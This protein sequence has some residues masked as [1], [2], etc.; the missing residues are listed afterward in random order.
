MMRKWVLVPVVAWI[1]CCALSISWAGEP[2]SDESYQDYLKMLRQADMRDALQTPSQVTQAAPKPE[3]KTVASMPEAKAVASK[4]EVK[5]A[6]KIAEVKSAPAPAKAAKSAPVVSEA[7]TAP[8]AAEVKATPVA[9][10]AKAAPAI[11]EAKTTPA[12]IEVKSLPAPAET[13]PALLVAQAKMEPA[14]ARDEE[15][16]KPKSGAWVP[17]AGTGGARVPISES[18]NARA[19]REKMDKLKAQRVTMN[20]KETDLQNVI[21]ALARYGELNVVIPPEIVKG[22]VTVYL[23]D[24]PLLTAFES[25]L[26]SH[27]LTYIVEENSTIIRIAPIPA[28]EEEKPKLDT[29]TIPLNWIKA[30]N[31]EMVLK[32]IVTEGTV[33]ADE[34]TNSIIITGKPET[35]TQVRRDIID[36][37]D[38]PDKQVDIE[39]RFVELTKN[40]QRDLGIQTDISRVDKDRA[41]VFD[42]RPF[43]IFTV[44]P[45]TGLPVPGSEKTTNAPV[46]SF[47]VGGARNTFGGSASTQQ[48][49]SAGGLWSWGKKVDAFGQDFNLAMQIS[50]FENR[51]EA[52]TLANPRVTTLNNVAAN[53]KLVTAI[54]FQKLTLSPGGQTTAEAQFKDAGI[55]LKVTPT[56]TNNDF[57]K[58][59]IIGTQ[60]ILEG[61]AKLQLAGDVPIMA[62]RK[63]ETT[64]I[65]KDDETAALFGLRQLDAKKTISGVPWVNRIPILGWLFKNQSDTQNKTDLAVFVTPHI[66]K[67]PDMNDEQKEKYNRIN[68]RWDLPDYF[69]D[70]STVPSD[71]EHAANKK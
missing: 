54:P 52:E 63:S 20:F 7:K 42:V 13:K 50:A 47:S 61:T 6:P 5:P 25:L 58:L 40:A 43:S 55:E 57:V 62:T 56:I 39:A 67:T 34:M 3:A 17:E 15:A 30:K 4:P 11:A 44:D 48:I 18:P 60:D 14:A 31:L 46:D 65:V 29:V 16:K 69:F 9:V 45:K 36:K 32:P 8:A 27:G 28:K 33:N 19:M 59:N 22:S 26:K 53:I 35:I 23:D 37:L 64:V 1:A 70:D 68:L 49:F 71:D 2:A 24:V 21:R 38:I 66:I 10:E 51:G 12:I 41:N